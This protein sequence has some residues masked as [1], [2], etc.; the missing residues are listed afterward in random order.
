MTKKDL[1]GMDTGELFKLLWAVL[2]NLVTRKVSINVPVAV[3]VAAKLMNVSQKYIRV[4]IQQGVLTFG[5]AVRISGT[6]YSYYI[7]PSRLKQFLEGAAPTSEPDSPYYF[8]DS[9]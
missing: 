7:S 1:M 4:G 9:E 3:A 8:E 5:S 6:K 2:D